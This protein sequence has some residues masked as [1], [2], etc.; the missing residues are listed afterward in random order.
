MTEM[1]SAAALAQ[2][3]RAGRLTPLD[4][5]ERCL[6]AIRTREGDV[7][8]FTALDADA[9]LTQARAPGLAARPLAGLP[10]G[11]K[12]II[13]TVD[14]PTGRGSPIYTGY[15]PVAD[16]AIVRMAVRA[17]GLIAGKMST[18]EFA[19]MQPSPTRN[20]RRLSHTPGGSS[21]G[22]AAA[23]AAGM[24]PITLGTQTGGSIIRPASFCGVT[25]YKPSFKLLPVL[26][27]KPFAWSLD[28]LGLFGAHVADVAFA[29]A[30]IS[31]RD[32]IPADDGHVPHFALVSTARAHLAAPD[33][34][35]ALEAAARAAQK[36][37]ARVSV[38]DLPAEVEAADAACGP[39]QAFE[40]ALA[41]ADE[42][43]R[44]H[45]ELSDTLASY[46][47]SAQHVTPDEYD[48]ARRASRRARHALADAAAGFDAI[49]T[50]SATGEAPAGHATTGSPVFNRLWTLTGAPCVNVAGLTG[51]SGLPIGVQ[52]V[53][54]FGRDRA[55]LGAARFLERA[56][57]DGH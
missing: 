44:H 11:V 51:A 33:A 45:G 24:L 43:D 23:V 57:H 6:E 48:A 29:A 56:I 25:G 20:P 54:R 41:F 15:R 10:V 4:V 18:T 3:I 19:F 35:A 7:Q 37:G 40:A 22:S 27:L 34:H 36:A 55:T 52:V 17:G 16:A 21:A 30:A 46:L 49:L 1:L 5:A 47:A 50:F 31:G 2:A 32:L 9:L 12:D 38:L 28:T 42:W 8:A 39:V 14:F 13:D 53:G 26:G